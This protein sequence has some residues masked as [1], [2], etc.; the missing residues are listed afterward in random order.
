METENKDR[1]DAAASDTKRIVIPRPEMGN[2]ELAEKCEE[3][4]D[5]L[6]KS[7]GNA[8]TLRVPVDIDR[9]PDMLFSELIRRFRE[10]LK[11]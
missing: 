10:N 8:W 4:I 6:C 7:G 5:K 11:V 1:Q 9:D 3:W 2:E